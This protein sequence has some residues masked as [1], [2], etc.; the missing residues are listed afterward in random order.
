MQAG[1]GSDD[2]GPKL[3]GQQLAG[4]D[5][6]PSVRF[7]FQAQPSRPQLGQQHYVRGGHSVSPSA[8]TATLGSSATATVAISATDAP[9]W[10]SRV[11]GVADVAVAKC[12]RA[13]STRMTLDLPTVET[14]MRQA[15]ISTTRAA[16]RRVLSRTGPYC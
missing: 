4:R 3:R 12:R 14:F 1:L 7:G 10:R 5:V 13:G 9:Y 6:Y 16:S 8:S 15:S 11:A 2:P